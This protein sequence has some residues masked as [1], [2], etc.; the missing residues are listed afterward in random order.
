MDLKDFWSQIR[1]A[2]EEK[3][4]DTHDDYA[5]SM[6]TTV[7]HRWESLNV[8]DE[9]SPNVHASATMRPCLSEIFCSA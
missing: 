1:M 4:E 7:G 5:T 8:Q 9:G 3:L 6:A 2:E